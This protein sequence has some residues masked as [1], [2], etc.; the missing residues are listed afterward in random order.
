MKEILSALGS[1]EGAGNSLFQGAEG[2]GCEVR[3]VPVFCSAPNALHGIEVRRVR[4]QPFDRDSLALGEPV[5]D[6]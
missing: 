2:V 4:R 6:F 5:L 1:A 3:Q